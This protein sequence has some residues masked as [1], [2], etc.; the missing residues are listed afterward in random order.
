MVCT[1]LGSLLRPLFYFLDDV[2]NPQSVYKLRLT[3]RNLFQTQNNQQQRVVVN[4]NNNNNNNNIQR[5]PF[6][7]VEE[8][9]EEDITPVRIIEETI[10]EDATVPEQIAQEIIIKDGTITHIGAGPYNGFLQGS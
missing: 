3:T 6:V 9:I 4:N 1:S 8:T 5:Q 10:I 2:S 7:V